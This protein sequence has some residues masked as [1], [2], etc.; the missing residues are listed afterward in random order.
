MSANDS[1]SSA[2]NRLLPHQRSFVEHYFSDTDSKTHLL[3]APSGSGTTTTIIELL[4]QF[5]SE[6]KNKRILFIANYKGAISSVGHML[7][8]RDLNPIQVDRYKYRE[9]EE[10]TDPSASPWHSPGVY[11]CTM[12][13]AVQSDIYEG[14]IS[15]PWDLLI[16]DSPSRDSS[17]SSKLLCRLLESA[18]LRSAIILARTPNAQTLPPLPAD[19][20]VTE[21]KLQDLLNWSKKPLWSPCKVELENVT[22]VPSS[23]DIKIQHLVT[24][25][26]E[27]AEEAKVSAYDPYSAEIW[28][29]SLYSRRKRRDG[30][31]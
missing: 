14:L 28:L 8:E 9:L 24:E 6:S 23:Q 7:H 4:R 17:M 25:I 5:L 10:S 20:S 16:Y 2:R 31:N 22:F 13:F 12:Q 26:S 15:S 30:T 19:I 29:R 11:L 3:I 18:Q 21:W 1:N 27:L